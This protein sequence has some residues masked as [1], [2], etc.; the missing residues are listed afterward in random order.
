MN[1]SPLNVAQPAPQIAPTRLLTRSLAHAPAGNPSP[2]ESA[3]GP[4]HR[5][6]ID[7]LRGVA[8]LSVLAV[9]AFPQQVTGGFIGVDI[10]FVL[11]GYLIATIIAQSLEAGHFS[12]RDFY[13]RRARR[14]FPALCV[15]LGSCLL[16]S[17][18]FTFPSEA[19][20]I[21]KHVAAGSV[22][23]SNIALWMEAGY[24]D[25]A[26]EAKPLLH[27][28]SLGIEEQFYLLWPLA[29]ALVFR[30]RR[31]AL[32]IILALALFSFALNVI[33]VVNRA[34]GTFFLLPTRAWE[35][36][37]GVLLAYLTL[38]CKG[39]P[40]N[41]LQDRLSRHQ[42][43]RAAQAL[44]GA[45]ALLGA[46]LIGIAFG[47]LDKSKHFPGWWALLPTLG[48]MLLLAAGH[49]AWFNRRILS[50]RVL[51]FYGA[52]SYPLYLWHWPLLVFPLLLGVELDYSVRVLILTASV[53]LAALTFEFVERP[54][55]FGRLASRAPVA[56][57]AA[58]ALIGAGGFAL[59]QSDGLLAVYPAQL[60]R[61]AQ[62]EV[63]FD[64]GAYRSARCFLDLEQGPS[65]YAAECGLPTAHLNDTTLLW[66]D[67]HAASLYPGL[68]AAAT[69]AA[70]D[71]RLAQFTKARCPP[72]AHP[73]SSSSSARC[74]EANQFVLR[75][76]AAA[77]PGTVV[78]AAHWSLYSA[79]SGAGALRLDE[80]RHTVKWL[81]DHGVRRVVVLGNL[82]TWTAPLPR[83]L[84]TAWK[85]S[86]LIPERSLEALD[87]ASL[88]MDGRV[89]TALVGTR[90]VFVSPFD[91]LCTADGCLVSRRHNG[92]TYPM[93]HDTS[94]LTVEG[95]AML[96]QL[97]RSSLL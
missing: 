93:A 89:R 73:P 58:L 14:I 31:H 17:A 78:L 84:L 39:Q 59:Q 81:E 25:S 61:I 46:G 36:L 90:A 27:L 16:F 12:Y 47:C 80:L 51:V 41:A 57:C 6:D 33:W 20:Q 75:Q 83:V 82:P 3:A 66:G 24:F 63:G 15:V 71:H 35:L 68:A 22:F 96:V 38:Q 87:P 60:R 10:F 1:D 65:D 28:W 76:I 91:A 64:F 97:H 5:R 52:I 92:V 50:N 62:A 23:A 49:E 45:I 37:F 69:D 43:P 34:K 40:L 19:R 86:G 85:R 4:T 79:F 2:D 44:P 26:S 13:A 56:L 55:R 72:L 95:S 32:K 18:L 21:G 29:A 53:A 88:A 11:S 42:M 54:L 67:S 48:T 7:G 9:H 77:P 94:H 74:A 8:V 30:L 70:S